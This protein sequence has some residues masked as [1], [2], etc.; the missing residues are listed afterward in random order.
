MRQLDRIHNLDEL[1]MHW[2]CVWM[3]K[4][5]TDVAAELLLRAKPTIDIK[6]IESTSA[7]REAMV[8]RSMNLL[9]V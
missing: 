6:R 7:F 3:L 8:Q 4:A 1:S 5:T 9:F 2:R